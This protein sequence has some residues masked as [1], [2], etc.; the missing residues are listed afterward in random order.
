MGRLSLILFYVLILSK[1][2]LTLHSILTHTHTS[3]HL[4]IQRDISSQTLKYLYHASHIIINPSIHLSCISFREQTNDGRIKESLESIKNT[5]I[6]LAHMSHSSNLNKII[7]QSNTCTCECMPY[8]TY[9]VTSHNL[10]I[11]AW[12]YHMPVHDKTKKTLKRNPN[13]AC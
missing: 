13:L 7:S 10:C 11:N 4:S 6:F 8:L 2:H 5:N 1:T 12:S 3:I 9:L